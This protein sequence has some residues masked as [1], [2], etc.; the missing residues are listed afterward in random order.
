MTFEWPWPIL[1]QGQ[2][3]L[4]MVFYGK[5]WKQWIFQKLL[6]PVT[7][8]LVDMT[9]YWDYE[10]MWVLQVKVISLP[11]IFQVLYVLCFTR[12]RYQVSVYRTT[13]PLVLSKWCK[14]NSKQWIPGSK[15]SSQSRLILVCTVCPDLSVRK[16]RV[17]TDNVFIQYKFYNFCHGFPWH[18]AVSL[19]WHVFWSYLASFPCYFDPGNI[20]T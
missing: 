4:L 6:Q 7:W 17:I 5:K 3:W 1:R 18:F 8:K 14:G 11:Y 20:Y 13:G 9:T 15:C 10:G 19:L 12:S 2:I 16:H